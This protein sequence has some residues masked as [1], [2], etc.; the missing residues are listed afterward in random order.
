GSIISLVR[1]ARP[2]EKEDTFQRVI[3]D[4]TAATEQASEEWPALFADFTKAFDDSRSERASYTPYLNILNVFGL[5]YDELCHSRVLAWYLDEKS[6][7]EQGSLFLK[8]LAD[9]LNLTPASFVN[10]QVQREKPDRVA[11]AV[12]RRGDF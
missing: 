1:S 4:F 9:S 6:E 7:H 10:Y 2:S 5:K 12:F 3:N 8:A 11:V